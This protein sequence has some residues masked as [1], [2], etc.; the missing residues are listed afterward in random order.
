MDLDCTF[1][2]L[3]YDLNEPFVYKK[4]STHYLN[5]FRGFKFNN[6]TIQDETNEYIEEGIKYIFNHMNKTICLS[7]KPAYEY[8]KKVDRKINLL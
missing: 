6:L 2:K 1:Y 3:S 4:K 7:D 8:L 5:L